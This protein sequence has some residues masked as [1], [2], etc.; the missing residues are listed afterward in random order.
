MDPLSFLGVYHPRFMCPRC[1]ATAMAQDPVTV[2][3]AM[4]AAINSGHAEADH[5]PCFACGET[6]TV[7]RLNRRL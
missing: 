4:N 5:R 2:G 3:E 1:L 6:T 7:L